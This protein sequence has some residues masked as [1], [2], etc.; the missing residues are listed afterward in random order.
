MSASPIVTAA[1]AQKCDV[2]AVDIGGTHAR[3]AIAMVEDGRVKSL[4]APTTLKTAEHASFQTA[5][6]A[7]AALNTTPLPR[8]VAIAFA[9]PVSGE[10]LQL[11]NSHW[12]VRP[13]LIPERLDVDDYIVV[14]DFGAVGHAVAQ[15][16]PDDF[17]HL[18][19]PKRAT[20]VNGVISIIGPGTGLGVAQLMRDGAAYR[21]VETEGGHGDFAP[22]D[23]FEDGLLAAMRQQTRRVSVERIVSGPGIRA[24]YEA[25]ARVE[26]HVIEAPDD[27]ALW[28]AALDGSDPLAIAALDRFCM[29]LGSVAGDIAL[30]QGASAVVIA[31]GLGARLV[32]HLPHSGFAERFAAKGRFETMLRDMP[33]KLITL[34][35]PGLFGAAAAFARTHI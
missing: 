25:L 7:F 26:G 11:T 13:A 9:G 14:N 12:V 19:G 6:Q 18:C 31:G 35:E 28:T 34:S 2:V 15:A 27:K 5:W 22:L 4:G 1:H 17:V 24:L 23:G 29:T 3:F 33:V 32:N 16:E 10:V 30:I 8:A 20:P 21:V